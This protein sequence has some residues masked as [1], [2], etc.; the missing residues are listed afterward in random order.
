MYLKEHDRYTT[1]ETERVLIFVIKVHL[2]I[3]W[4]IC[5]AKW[6]TL[7]RLMKQYRIM[8]TIIV[9]H[10]KK[11]NN[12]GSVKWVNKD[13]WIHEKLKCEHFIRSNNENACIH[14]YIYHYIVNFLGQWFFSSP[15][16]DF[17]VPYLIWKICVSM[18]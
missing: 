16:I 4:L 8:Y 12:F 18:Q 14:K 7:Q 1:I 11:Y 17:C 15:H 3:S 2:P 5:K 6:Y 9:L 10:C 13:F